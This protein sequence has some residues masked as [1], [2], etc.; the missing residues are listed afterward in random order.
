MYESPRE[1]VL[2]LC[3]E[4]VLSWEDVAFMALKFMTETEIAEMVR[5]NEIDLEDE[6][7]E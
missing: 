4:G 3:E 6:E 7:D 1:R 5:V 2:E